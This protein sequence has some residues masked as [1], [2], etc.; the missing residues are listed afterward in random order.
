MHWPPCQTLISH[1]VPGSHLLPFP[2]YFPHTQC[3]LQ[4][5]ARVIFLED[6]LEHF[7]VLLTGFS[8]L[9]IA[10][11]MRFRSLNLSVKALSNSVLPRLH[12]IMSPLL[13]P[14]LSPSSSRELSCFQMLLLDWCGPSLWL[15]SSSVYFTLPFQFWVTSGT[16]AIHYTLT[17]IWAVKRSLLYESFILLFDFSL[18]IYIS[19]SIK[20]TA[21]Q[22]MSHKHWSLQLLKPKS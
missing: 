8:R 10:C 12:C 13:P 20:A 9:P 18:C 19:L 2:F 11:K 16:Q 3:F 5:S 6:H 1:S 22:H 15:S 17:K 14:S 7:S 21:S 4:I